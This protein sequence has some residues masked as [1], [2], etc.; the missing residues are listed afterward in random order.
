MTYNPSI[1]AGA[2]TPAMSQPKIQTNFSKFAS[3]FAVNHSAMNSTNQGDHE[4]VIFEKQT[5]DPGITQ[6]LA[7]LYAKQT[8]SGAGSQPQLFVRIPKFLPTNLDTTNAP[9]NPMQLSYNQVN[10][11]GPQYQS[12]IA[13]NYLVFIGSTSNIATPIVLSPSPTQIIAV[14]TMPNSFNG[15]TPFQSGATV[16]QPNTF[17]INSFNAT[18]SYTFTW[19]AIAV[20]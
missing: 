19:M 8:V 20:S 7:V 1:P 3:Q 18:G 2:D 5:V 17:K 10:I 14:F 12:F 15:A 13:G 9:N 6:D 4:A 16:T 11:A